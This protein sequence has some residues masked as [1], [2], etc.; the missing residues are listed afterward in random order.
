[1]KR[2]MKKFMVACAA[3]SAITVAAGM[4]AMAATYDEATNTATYTVPAAADGTQMTVLVIPQDKETNV[5]DEDI[6]YINQDATGGTGVDGTAEL[7]AG[8]LAK[9]TYLVKV[10][11]YEG[12]TF[13]IASETFKIGGETPEPIYTLGDVNADTEI[14]S[15]DAL[16][17][18][19][20]ETGDV[21]FTETEQLA[22]N[23]NKDSEI[24]S[25][26]ALQILKYEVGDI[27]NF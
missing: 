16:A 20:Y 19:K 26:D 6:L 13:K 25:K 4:S 1:M 10:G 9:G 7:K 22:A 12:E 11:Y 2:S 23:V 21:D 14:D 5:A 17:V 24:D 18:L 3:V 27:D 8:T 15:K